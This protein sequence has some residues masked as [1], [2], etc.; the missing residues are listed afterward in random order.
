VTE[1]SGNRGRAQ[2]R[3]AL[4]AVAAAAIIAVV[5]L[6]TPLSGRASSAGEICQASQLRISLGPETAASSHEGFPII[7]RSR[8]SPCTL[9]GFALVSGVTSGGQIVTR[10]KDSLGGYLPVPDHVAT[11]TVRVG[12]PAAALLASIDPGVLSSPCSGYPFQ[13]FSFLSVTPPGSQQA[14]QLRLP[15]YSGT[16]VALCNLT[17]GPIAAGLT[18]EPPPAAIP[19][20]SLSPSRSCGLVSGPVPAQSIRE[21]GTNC[22]VARRVAGDWLRRV[23]RDQCSRFSCTV[24]PFHCRPSA[25]H[26]P[27]PVRPALRGIPLRGMMRFVPARAGT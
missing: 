27:L 20:R 4:K 26:I 19:P 7:F 18:G 12:Q 22:G 8:G 1:T 25:P 17:I 16:P 24:P 6:V 2:R 21:R 5:P 10:A 11:V 13:P 23:E 9:R 14:T 3:I 15:L